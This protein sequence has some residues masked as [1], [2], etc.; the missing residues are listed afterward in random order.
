MSRLSDQSSSGPPP[1]PARK[2][3]GLRF[4]VRALWFI[5]LV[6]AVAIVVYAASTPLL[7]AIGEQL[8]HSDSVERV[9]AML[10]PASALDRVI[11]AAALYRDGYAPLIVLT[12]ERPDPAEEFLSSRGIVIEGVEDRRRRILHAL[13]VPL[14]A[15]VV[16]DEFVA[17]TADEAR[18]FAQWAK[19]RPIRTVIIVTSPS[20]TARSRMT[21]LRVLQ[22]MRVRVLVHPSTL[23]RFRG[24]T[25]WHSRDTLREGFSEWQKLVYYRLFELRRLTPVSPAVPG[26]L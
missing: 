26:A 10:V 1:A 4:G 20:H 23:A 24:D 12:R 17:S 25:W 22:D 18:I 19:T 7:T 2:Q 3:H 21:F 11:E 6:A 8:I 15:I 14:S 5:G 16:L 9:D 13:G